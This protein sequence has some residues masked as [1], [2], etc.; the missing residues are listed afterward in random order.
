[1]APSCKWP[2]FKLPSG[3]YE[4]AIAAARQILARD[5][6]RE[7]AYQA[8]MRF[9]AATGDSAAALLTFE[10]C[11]NLLSEELGADPSPA[12][13]L[14]HQR[15]LNGEIEAP[16]PTPHPLFQPAAAPSAVWPQ[17]TL[18]PHHGDLEPAHFVGREAELRQLQTLFDQA[19]QGQGGLVLVEGEAG[20]GKSWLVHKLLRYCDAAGASIVSG[21]CSALEQSMP[22]APLAN[23]LD[24]YFQRLAPADIAALPTATLSQIAQLVPVLRD[25]VADLPTPMQFST[26]DAAEHRLHLIEAL[27]GLFPPLAQLGPLVLFLDDLQWVDRETLAV[28]SRLAQR[29]DELQ[30]LIVLAYRSE[31]LGEHAEL[32]LFHG[33]LRH[34]QNGAILSVPPLTVEHVRQLMVAIV[35]P[36]PQDLARIAD[37]IHKVTGGNALFVAE[38]IQAWHSEMRALPLED[39]RILGGNVDDGSARTLHRSGRVQELI[40]AR[41]KALPSVAQELLQ[42][43]AVVGRDF[44]LDLLEATAQGDPLAALD[45]LLQQRLLVEL[46]DT[47]LRFAQELVRQVV[48]DSINPL[49]RRRLHVRIAQA[50]EAQNPRTRPSSELAFHYRQAGATH[51]LPFAR[52]SVQAG[53]QLL[54]SLGFDQAIAHFDAALATLHVMDDSPP[55][56]TRQALQGRGLACESLLDAAG[57]AETYG[58]LQAWA[59]AHADHAL[60]IATHSRYSSALTL[61][62]HQRKSN[63]LVAEL[64][65][66]LHQTSS[67]QQDQWDA[68]THLFADLVERRQRINRADPTPAADQWTSYC[69]PPAAIAAPRQALLGLLE[70]T[71]AVLPLFDY[72]WTLLAQGQ[73]GEATHCLEEVIELAD[74]T[75]QPAVAAAAYHQLA[76]TARIL[77][78][79]DRC[80]QLIDRSLALSRAAGQSGE[81]AALQPRLTR[82]GLTLER[83]ELGH[84]AR[85]YQAVLDDLAHREGFQNY[86]HS[87]N[88]GLGLVALA[89]G[90]TAAAQALLETA[91]GDPFH[92]T[93][94][95]H[96]RAWIG[97]AHLAHAQGQPDE[98]AHALRRALLFAG[99]RSLLEEYLLALIATTQLLPHSSPVEALIE[100]VLGY[101][102]TIRLLAAETRLLDARRHVRRTRSG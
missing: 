3:H 19:R 24:R 76:I 26:L 79:R 12:T 20:V 43:A 62:G 46:P 66:T 89:Q 56:L 49:Q 96:V 11:R 15:I 25:R 47:R 94:Y 85:Q 44:S 35:N 4:E 58:R 51:Q 93:P 83:G 29:A 16:A 50:I 6:V 63:E 65:A 32:D 73:I 2:S 22:F 38:A 57:V 71:Y 80:H 31:M 41:V 9:Q 61:L 59:V 8:L 68:A 88:I 14:L 67:Q 7:T 18:L 27:V 102:Q 10:R 36:Q 39:A 64:Y 101:V 30:L 78:D 42:M 86:R 21:V 75:A 91:V 74:A 28:L 1:M 95:S 34:D 45:I 52:Y 69:A 54:H 5:P 55:E 99:E 17:V 77:G 82:A 60:L 40:L 13:Q 70:P 90:D 37:D 87:A 98:C 81:L 100:S 53:N 33:A 72:G 23:L 84:A 97:L 48:Y 92:I